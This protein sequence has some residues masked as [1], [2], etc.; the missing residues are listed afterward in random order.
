MDPITQQT[1]LAAAGAG[2]NPVYVDDVFSIDVFDGNGSSQTI[3]NGINLAGEGGMVWGKTRTTTVAHTITDTERGVDKELFTNTTDA[4]ATRST[5]TGSVTAFNSNGFTTNATNGFIN[6]SG[7]NA[8]SWTF[9]KCPG[10]FDVV[11]WTGNGVNG[12]EI[13]HNLGADVGSIW[14]KSTSA[15]DWWYVWHKDLPTNSIIRLESSDG[16]RANEAQYVFGDNT[17][18]INPTSTVFTVADPSSNDNGETYVAYLFAHDDQSFGTNSDEAIIKCGTYEGNATTGNYVDVGFEPQWLMIKNADDSSTNWVIFDSMRGFHAKGSQPRRLSANSSDTEANNLEVTREPRGF[19]LTGGGTYTNSNNHTFVYVAIRRP[20]KPPESATDVFAMDT[21]NSSSI[22]PAYDSNFPVDFAISRIVSSGGAPHFTSR[23]T[24]TKFLRSDNSF[25]ESS[26][27]D[28]SWDSNVGWG[29][30]WYSQ[31]HSWMFRRAPEFFDVVTY[32]GNGSARSISHNLTVPPELLIVKNRTDA[33]DWFAYAE[34]LGNGKELSINLTG[35]ANNSSRWQYTTPT[36]TAFYV[37]SNSNVNAGGSN[38]IAY[39]FATLPG[40]SKVGSYTGTG[41]DG[42]N[43]DCG[44]TNGARFVMV[45]RTDSSG[46]WFVADTS[47]GINAGSDPFIKLNTS[48]A[49][50]NSVD[51]IDAYSAGFT[52]NGTGGDFNDSSGTYLFLAIA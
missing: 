1:A 7:H 27:A 5:G 46:D 12:R 4:E 33:H 18:P 40:I 29:K 24:G 17:N 10:F 25:A 22:I 37:S 48:D 19:S 39:L 32:T 8:C 11:T 6:Y 44:F 36:S 49:E 35:K 21:G 41:S 42:N 52:I 14:I 34:P 9:R 30:N 23:L 50:N 16:L 43:V 13:S 26:D 2:G 15:Q 28:Y 3:T 45:K 38:F 47:R 51:W 31:Y 20:H